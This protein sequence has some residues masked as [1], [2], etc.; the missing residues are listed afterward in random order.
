MILKQCH[1]QSSSL[2]TS[3]LTFAR[4]SQKHYLLPNFLSKTT[5]FHP[6]FSYQLHLQIIRTLFFRSPH[7]SPKTINKPLQNRFFSRTPRTVSKKVR[8]ASFACLFTPNPFAKQTLHSFATPRR[9]D[10]ISLNICA[11]FFKT[12]YKINVPASI[13]VPKNSCIKKLRP[14]ANLI[15]RTPVG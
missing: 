13:N 12:G 5:Y 14:W 7:S 6:N 1:P 3:P 4:I 15:L 9:C 8:L 11:N 10:Q 2:L